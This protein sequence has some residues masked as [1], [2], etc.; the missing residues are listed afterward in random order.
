[1][2]CYTLLF[3]VII[4]SRLLFSIQNLA[5][6]DNLQ[7]LLPLPVLVMLICLL[8][9]PNIGM[10]AGSVSAILIA[11]LFQNNLHLFLYLFF[12]S[13]ATTFACYQVVKRSDLVK[14]GNII[15]IINALLIF[16][17]GIS[18][19]V[20]SVLWFLYNGIIGFSNG[21]LCAMISFAFLPYFEALFKITT[22]LG[23][24]ENANLNHPLLKKLM[25]NAP[26]TYQHSL[27]VA[28]L[29][30]AAAESIGADVILT[31][32]GAYFHDI[33][34]MKRPIFFRKSIFQWKP[35]R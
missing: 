2:L 31:R 27:M 26:G 10:P 14:A 22:S 35:A 16:T 8:L 20:S 9:T 33:G 18:N 24:L 23:L 7:F 32:I 30:E 11:M 29:S 25:L 19:D 15:G 3:L 4:V 34:K 12:A 1:M 21:L 17:I 13:C 6:V 28:N 5:F